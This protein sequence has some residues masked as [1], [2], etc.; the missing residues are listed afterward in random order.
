MVKKKLKPGDLVCA[1]KSNDPLI[2]KGTC[3]VFEKYRT[4]GNKK[5]AEVVFNFTPPFKERKFVSASGGPVVFIPLE[6][7]KPTRKKD[8]VI[9]WKWKDNVP[10][11]GRAE[12][13]KRK[14]NIFEVDLTKKNINF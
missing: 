9:F 8:T 1:I 10:R 6:N 14:V 3:G 11:A 2:K 4:E 7:I 13:F 5:Y 12:Y